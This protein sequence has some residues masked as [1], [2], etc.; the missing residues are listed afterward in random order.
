MC[1]FISRSHNLLVSHLSQQEAQGEAEGEV[2]AL[3]GAN[4]AAKQATAVQVTALD[5]PKDTWRRFQTSLWCRLF[6]GGGQ[7]LQVVQNLQVLC[8]LTKYFG[9]F[10]SR[11]S[12]CLQPV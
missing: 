10:S 6:T 3:S 8:S 9:C 7:N 4:M 11:L 2:L 5:I 1:T 12:V